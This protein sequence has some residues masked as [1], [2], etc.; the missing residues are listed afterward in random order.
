MCNRIIQLFS[1]FPL[2]S[3]ER[4]TVSRKGTQ[5]LGVSH[6]RKII[7]YQNKEYVICQKLVL[8]V[9]SG[10]PDTE[11]EMKARGRRPRAFIVSRCLQ[12]LMKHEARVFGMTSQTSVR[13][14]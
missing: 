9:S 3:S 1:V 7:Y 12:P 13:I 6:V 5:V 11:K 2:S 10:I 4:F 14:K 8:R